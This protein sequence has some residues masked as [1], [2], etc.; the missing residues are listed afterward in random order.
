VATRCVFR[1]GRS[2]SIHA[3]KEALPGLTCRALAAA[4]D[5]LYNEAQLAIAQQRLDC[6]DDSQLPVDFQPSADLKRLLAAQMPRR[7]HLVAAAELVSVVDPSH[8]QSRRYA[9]DP[10]P[11]RVCVASPDGND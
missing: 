3:R 2:A 4:S 1:A 9:H 7:D 6:A 8:R 10:Q 11:K 5:K